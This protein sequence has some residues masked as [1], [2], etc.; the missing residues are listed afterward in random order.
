MD[1][2]IEFIEKDD[3]LLASIIDTVITLER[4]REILTRIGRECSSLGYKKVLL[5][6]RTVERREVPTHEILNLS[7]EMERKGFNKTHLA[8]LCQPH[9]INKDAGL[10]SL[11][12]FEN[13]YVV[14]HFS[15]KEE[16]IEWITSQQ[17]I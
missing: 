5:D 17:S 12:T 11:F 16:A 1:G 6:E 13:E 14:Q 3:Y 10:L 2:N 7:H 9:L 4:A 15:S 8:F